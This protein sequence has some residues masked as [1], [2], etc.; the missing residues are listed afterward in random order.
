MFA[1]EVHK[2]APTTESANAAWVGAHVDVLSVGAFE[3]DS[4]KFIVRRSGL[5]VQLTPKEFNILLTLALNAGETVSQEKLVKAAWGDDY[6]EDMGG[7]AVY[8]RRIRRK[9]EDYPSNPR[10]V[11]TVRGEGYRFDSEGA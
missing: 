4:R 1:L 11:L 2:A 9:V 5:P 8:I 6:S 7:L 10:F 3:F